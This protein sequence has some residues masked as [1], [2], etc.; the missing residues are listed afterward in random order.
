MKQAK[1]LE[2][3]ERIRGDKKGEFNKRFIR[4]PSQILK[5]IL[6]RV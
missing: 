3:E 5:L 4:H 6:H 2:E 1:D